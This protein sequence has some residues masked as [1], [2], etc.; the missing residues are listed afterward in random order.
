MFDHYMMQDLL[1]LSIIEV[2]ICMESNASDQN[3]NNW[4]VEWNVMFNDHVTIVFVY[5]RSQLK[6]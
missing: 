2:Y 5:H 4:W 3:T 6:K 1:G